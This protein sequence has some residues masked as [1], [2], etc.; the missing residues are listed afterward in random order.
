MANSSLF[1]I[2]SIFFNFNKFL[3]RRPAAYTAY[4]AS[5]ALV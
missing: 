4:T 3:Q 5:A 2:N 1:N